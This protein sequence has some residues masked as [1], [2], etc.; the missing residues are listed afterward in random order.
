MRL[1]T[2]PDRDV[3]SGGWECRT[4]GGHVLVLERGETL[5]N[6][7]RLAVFADGRTRHLESAA[8][9]DTKKKGKP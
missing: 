4:G 8:N 1:E 6:Y 3:L 5:K 2:E 7:L 9:V